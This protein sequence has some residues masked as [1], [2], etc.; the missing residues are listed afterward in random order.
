RPA[1]AMTRICQRCRDEL[2]QGARRCPR[3][4][5]ETS[6]EELFPTAYLR[7]AEN[8][9]TRPGVVRPRRIGDYE[10]IEEIARGGMGVIYKARQVRLNRMVA[11]KLILS[12]HLASKLDVLR[13]RAEAEAAGTLRHPN[14]VAIYETG[15][16]EGQHYFSM[17][18]IDG[19]DLEAISKQGS[20]TAKKA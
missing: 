7:N 3:C 16:C 14:I 12:R 11:L 9:E 5:F 13:F 4:L 8:L 6:F 17:E 1:T 10:L 18:Y 15:E 20:L 19:R 2:P